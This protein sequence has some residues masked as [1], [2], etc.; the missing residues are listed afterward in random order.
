MR[1]KTFITS[2]VLA[3]SLLCIG[4][5]SFAQENSQ[6]TIGFGFQM[7]T[8]GLGKEFTLFGFGFN[9]TYK[10]IYVDFL[11]NGAEHGSSSQ[12]GTWNDNQGIA[13]HLGYKVPINEKLSLIP[14]IGYGEIN[15]GITN[16]Y[17]YSADENGIHNSYS[18]TWR[19]GGL[20]L[21]ASAVLNMGKYDIY[22]TGTL[23][24]VSAGI[25]VSF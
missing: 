13:V 14:M 10:S 4:S 19:H 23:W 17:K 18:A 25:G 12:V 9:F 2:T 15:E 3:L 7:G 22:L 16:G 24:S 6:K 8:I 20:D 11:V 21:G 1:I 5:N